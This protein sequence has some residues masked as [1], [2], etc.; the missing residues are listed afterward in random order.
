MRFTSAMRKYHGLAKGTRRNWS[1]SYTLETLNLLL[2][3]QNLNEDQQRA[4]TAYSM[5]IL[6]R[7][8][9]DGA[10]STY[11]VPAL[12]ALARTGRQKTLTVSSQIASMQK[13]LRSS[14]DNAVGY[15]NILYYDETASEIDS[16]FRNLGF[17]YPKGF[18]P[19]YGCP[20]LQKSSSC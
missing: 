6:R 9:G 13:S 1:P 18:K 16:A 19:E 5:N 4:L 17:S 12:K 14:H 20:S 3:E 15:A 10:S 11:T 2:D 7:E 8:K